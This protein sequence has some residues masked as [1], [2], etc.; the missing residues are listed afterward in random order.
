MSEKNRTLWIALVL[1]FAVVATVGYG[2]DELN[3]FKLVLFVSIT[4]FAV[5]IVLQLSRSIERPAKV[6][7]KQ[8]TSRAEPTTTIPPARRRWLMF[9]VLALALLALAGVIPA[10]SGD[11]LWKCLLIAVAIQTGAA[12]ATSTHPAPLATPILLN[13]P[14]PLAGPVLPT[15]VS[16]EKVTV[17]SSVWNRSWHS[18]ILFFAPESTTLKI[19]IAPHLS[20][21]ETSQNRTTREA[22]Q[23]RTEKRKWQGM[24]GAQGTCPSPDDTPVLNFQDTLNFL[25]GPEFQRC[26]GAENR[27][28]RVEICLQMETFTFWTEPS[29]EK[30]SVRKVQFEEIP[31]AT[32]ARQTGTARFGVE[33]LVQPN[34]ARNP[35]VVEQLSQIQQ[36]KGSIALFS[37]W[38]QKK[39]VWLAQKAEKDQNKQNLTSTH[40]RQTAEKEA[41][42]FYGSGL[43]NM[44]NLVIDR[45]QEGKS[46]RFSAPNLVQAKP[47]QCFRDYLQ[48][49]NLSQSGQADQKTTQHIVGSI[50][51]NN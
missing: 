27:L 18:A 45:S 10:S 20:S 24:Q 1:F 19:V 43:Y 44:Y 41:V 6:S 23:L 21:M 9:L 49:T 22:D 12:V 30:P 42:V 50:R 33:V 16:Y 11:Q 31:L 4:A 17:F 51:P 8:L 38:I 39:E 36:S 15:P 13:G 48:K 2:T 25:N 28:R 5:L 7:K 40:Q 37:D 47:S 46:L 34:C 3:M 29:K 32:F 35:E 14:A 26:S